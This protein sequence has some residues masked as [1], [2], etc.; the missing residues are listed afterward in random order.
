MK[1]KGQK[2]KT[3]NFLHILHIPRLDGS[4]ETGRFIDVPTLGCE[5]GVTRIAREIDLRV[6]RPLV[7][8]LLQERF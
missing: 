5:V 8:A 7:P 4:H 1:K 3:Y 2:E 6:R